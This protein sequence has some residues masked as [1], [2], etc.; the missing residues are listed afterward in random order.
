MK[1]QGSLVT[2]KAF[3]A[4]VL[5]GLGL[6]YAIGL[7]ISARAFI[8][9]LLGKEMG[10]G[11]H[12]YPGWTIVHFASAF[13]FAALAVLQLLP[14]LRRRYPPLHRYS[15]RIA[16]FCGLVAAVT[17]AFIPFAVNPPRPLLERVYIVLYFTGVASFLLLGLR[18]ARRHD[19]ALHR[20]WMIRA[21]ASAGAVITQRIVFAILAMAFGIRN[22]AAFWIGFVTAF[23]LGW[24]INLALAEVWLRWRPS[25]SAQAVVN[26]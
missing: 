21:V 2:W 5:G 7:V 16:I 12:S 14:A 26:E 19:Y 1:R 25:R 13:V 4:L 15:G 20:Q 6:L 17:G 9:L 8:L 3:R 23:A 10:P 11:G 22:E 18:A 24:A